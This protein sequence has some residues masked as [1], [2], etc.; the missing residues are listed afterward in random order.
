MRS[1]FKT[2][3][4][5]VSILGLFLLFLPF[6]IKAQNNNLVVEYWDGTNWQPLAGPIFSERNFAPGDS[7]SREI[8]VKNNSSFPQNIAVEAINYPGYPDYENIPQTDLS[9]ALVIVIKEKNG[10]DLYGGSTGQKTLYDFYRKIGFNANSEHVL[11]YN[12]GSSESK[13]YEFLIYFPGDKGNEWQKTST[14]FD[15][16]IGFQG[17]EGIEGIGVFGGR[18]LGG[19]S[20]IPSALT[21]SEESVRVITTTETSVTITWTTSYRSTSQVIYS[22]YDE[23][24]NLNLADTVG[25]PPKYGYAHT[26]PEY[27]TPA[28]LNGVIFHKVTIE[29]LEPAT[30]YYFRCVSRGS[31]A[32]SREYSFVT[33]GAQGAQITEKGKIS[34]PKEEISQPPT[35][36]E[37]LT[38]ES[39]PEKFMVSKE[40]EGKQATQKENFT[41]FLL[42]ALITAIKKPWVIFLLI[43]CFGGLTFLVS[44]RRKK[45]KQKH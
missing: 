21:I 25:N 18:F 14:T 17:R 22:R 37:E 43:L 42:A 7:I 8:R 4:I 9:R 11:T 39:T 38:P 15:L 32:I 19:Q 5:N 13:I 6:L 10:P 20:I 26:T 33:E 28:F 1:L 40:W 35:T 16:L 31:L 34:I 2:I 30:T 24:H 12:L 45:K 41:S 23:P 29:G 3:L 27:D 36:P 44:E